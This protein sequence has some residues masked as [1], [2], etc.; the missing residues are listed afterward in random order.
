MG[1][2]GFDDW[3]TSIA[4]IDSRFTLCSYNY[5]ALSYGL[6]SI[7]EDYPSEYKRIEIPLDYVRAWRKTIENDGPQNVTGSSLPGEN[8]SDLKHASSCDN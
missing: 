2:P 8:H 4:T 3:G 1:V 6:S 5:Q 7:C